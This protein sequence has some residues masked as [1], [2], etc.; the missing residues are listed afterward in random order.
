[1][2]DDRRTSGTLLV[3]GASGMLGSAVIR[4]AMA[5]GTRVVGTHHQAPI[6]V[7]GQETVRLPLE[8]AAEL[9]S[10]V[11][12]IAPS[13]VIHCAALTN[14]DYCE[15]N[16]DEAFAINAEATAVMARAAA[17]CGARFLYVSTDAVFDGT[18]GWYEETDECRPVNVYSASKLRGEEGSLAE[19]ASAVV[20]RLAPFGW[21]ARPDKRSLAEWVLCELREGRAIAGFVDAVFTPMYAGDVARSLL[22][23]VRA[24][25]RTGVYHLGSRDA[26]SKYEFACTLASAANLP[27][28]NVR[29]ASILDH[30]FRAKRPLNVSLTT[31]KISR[32]TGWAMPTVREGIASMLRDAP[33][34]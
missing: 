18:R 6:T 10:I 23:L 7:A 28:G 17:A 5:Q 1:M 21:S 29:A 20:V 33:Q 2:S 30:A 15:E 13:A 12:R 31:A 26:M 8:D 25:E 16:A 14:V 27:R 19:H 24:P 32:D 9:E 11:K 3:T 34:T 22:A 4:L